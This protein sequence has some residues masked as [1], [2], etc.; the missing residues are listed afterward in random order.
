MSA[1]SCSKPAMWNGWS[2]RLP[3]RLADGRGQR[4]EDHAAVFGG[5]GFLTDES[6]RAV[7]EPAARRNLSPHLFNL[8]PGDEL[9]MRAPMGMFVCATRRGSVYLSLPGTDRAIPLTAARDVN[10]DRPNFQRCCYGVRYHHTLMYRQEWR[11]WRASIRTS[12]HAG[13][14]QTDPEW[15]GRTGH[16]RR[17]C[18]SH[19]RPPRCRCFSVRHEGHGGRRPQYLERDGL[20]QKADSLREVRLMRRPADAACGGIVYLRHRGRHDAEVDCRP[21]KESDYW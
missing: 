19:R 18:R 20:R 1:I 5:I 2:S 12:F 15:T 14:Q 11:R 3:I 6:F 4:Q 9:E 13:A 8:Q 17:I 16:V 7:P 21:L 10:R